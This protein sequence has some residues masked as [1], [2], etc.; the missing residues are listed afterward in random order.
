MIFIFKFIFLLNSFN[1]D[2]Y[3][4]NSYFP[5]EL[6]TEEINS[7]NNIRFYLIHSKKKIIIIIIII[8]ITISYFLSY[9]FKFYLK[10]KLNYRVE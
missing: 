3:L 1:R 8:I 5:S 10:I 6:N 2:D 9:S 7:E 4:Y